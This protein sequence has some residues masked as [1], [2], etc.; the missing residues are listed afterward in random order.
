MMKDYEYYWDK[1]PILKN[2]VFRFNL[3]EIQDVKINGLNAEKLFNNQELVLTGYNQYTVKTNLIDKFGEIIVQKKDEICRKLRISPNK[4]ANEADV[5]PE[6]AY[7]YINDNIFEDITYLINYILAN[8]QIRDIKGIDSFSYEFKD[9]PKNYKFLVRLLDYNSKLLANTIQKLYSTGPIHK[10]IESRKTYSGTKLV[11]SSLINPSPYTHYIK[12]Y[13]T[14]DTIL[15]QMLFQTT[16]FMMQASNI[17][18]DKVKNEELNEKLNYLSKN[19][20]KLLDE[21]HLWSFFS[22]DILEDN[23]IKSRLISQ[24]NPFYID[25]YK[26]FKLSRDIM[27]YMSIINPLFGESGLEMPI[28]EFYHIYE[29]WTVSKL[30]KFFVK[31]QF[32]I[33]DYQYG[34]YGRKAKMYFKLQNDELETVEIFWEIKFKAEDST[35]YGGMIKNIENIGLEPVKPDLIV[36]INKKTHKK[37]FIGD[38]KF[39]LKKNN[40]PLKDSIYDVL[41]YLEDLKRANLFKNYKVEG[42]LVYPGNF[43][44]RKVP[45]F[46]NDNHITI[47]SLNMFNQDF[48]NIFEVNE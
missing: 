17:L 22:L 26:I 20:H 43:S 18:K 10:E 46:E 8:I 38:I 34:E 35:Y 21:Y 31:N 45:D 12:Q 14:H 41:G 23:E 2:E 7:N 25:I 27:M 32:K 40:L 9:Y 3:N 6:D 29:I 44:S 5:A 30:L 28:K 48:E 24:N 33:N 15:N 47:M 39:R 42:L 36:L 4:I 13:H 11:L 19:S 1:D 16:Y 37:A